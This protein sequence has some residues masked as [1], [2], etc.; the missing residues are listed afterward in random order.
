MI[1]PKNIIMTGDQ[2]AEKGTTAWADWQRSRMKMALK[3]TNFEARQIVQTIRDMCSGLTPAWQLMTRQ[4]G[5]GFRT[6]EEFVTSPEGLTYPDYPKFRGMA[7]SEPGIM[8][9]R[10]YRLLTATP[11]R[12]GARTDREP[13]APGA[14]GSTPR[15]T[16]Q[17][18]AIKRAPPLVRKLYVAGL[19]DAKLAALL[20][21]DER[22]P[23][24]PERKAKADRALAAIRA[25]SGNGDE[26]AYR[27][28]VNDAVRRE[29][30]KA[31]KVPT[32]LDRLLRAW[33][34]ATPAERRAFLERHG[35]RPRKSK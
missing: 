35:L 7:L 10:E 11:D 16:T 27:K 26:A 28:A 12:M 33:E 23:S 19:I 32:G 31:T 34:K 4:D 8:N 5:I 15:T 13:H 17:L 24:Y 1:M 22:V 30:A 9:E 2:F 14:R 3:D 20:G 6:F 29:F 21:P 18:R 25:I